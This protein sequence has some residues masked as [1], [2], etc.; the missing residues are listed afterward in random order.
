MSY[1]SWAWQEDIIAIPSVESTMGK[2]N[3]SLQ[4]I[5]AYS[6]R[7]SKNDV[8]KCNSWSEI[9]TLI[10]WMRW[11]GECSVHCAK[12]GPFKCW[13]SVISSAE[14]IHFKTLLL[15]GIVGISSVIA[16][17][18]LLLQEEM[19][20]SFFFSGQE[21]A[22]MGHLVEDGPLAVIVDAVSWQDYLGG[23][24]QHHCSSRRA[25]HAV[26]VVGYNTAG[27][28]C[29]YTGMRINHNSRKKTGILILLELTLSFLGP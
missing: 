1:M 17:P 4:W 21:E 25:N 28:C 11:G 27:T 16:R 6:M 15:N 23:I 2:D 22:M 5:H 29:H 20:L 12:I 19:F 14:C 10:G 8:Q 3:M 18:I 13:N 24:I 7:S 26:L 9:D